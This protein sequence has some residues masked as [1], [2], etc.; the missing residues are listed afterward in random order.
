MRHLSHTCTELEQSTLRLP[1]RMSFMWQNM[2]SK[3]ES[4]DGQSTVKL[5]KVAQAQTGNMTPMTTMLLPKLYLLKFSLFQN[6][7]Q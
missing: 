5:C 4:P 6:V 3:P 7:T 2:L 1:N